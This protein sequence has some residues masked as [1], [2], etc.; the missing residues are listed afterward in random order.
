MYMAAAGAIRLKD[1]ATAQPSLCY[2][3]L[4]QP[5]CWNKDE[6]CHCHAKLC[7]AWIRRTGI[8][9]MSVRTACVIG[10]GVAFCT[11]CSC[12]NKLYRTGVTADS[13]IRSITDW[14]TFE[15][16]LA[17][18]PTHCSRIALL[19]VSRLRPY[20]TLFSKIYQ[21]NI[22]LCTFLDRKTNSA[23]TTVLAV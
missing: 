12:W 8:Q 7:R 11:D 2:F 5:F 10:L 20:Y 4:V 18:G 1:T 19:Y 6:Y 17:P 3:G 15:W 23:L 21:N 14:M 13:A 9:C 22:E 16:I